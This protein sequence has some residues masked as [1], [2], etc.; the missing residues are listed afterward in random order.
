M[1]KTDCPADEPQ[2]L[3]QYVET[4]RRAAGH[5]LTST[6]QLLPLLSDRQVE[7]GRKA[8]RLLLEIMNHE[9]SS[10]IAL[11]Q[12]REAPEPLA[13]T[14]QEAVAQTHQWIQ[15]LR[16]WILANNIPMKDS[17][18]LLGLANRF[19]MAGKE[20]LTASRQAAALRLNLYLGDYIL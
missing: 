1:N 11:F 13:I 16:S 7:E 6:G 9:L 14:L 18:R 4:L 17:I 3:R 2:R 5:L 12:Q 8:L 15:D 19:E 20:L 10:Q